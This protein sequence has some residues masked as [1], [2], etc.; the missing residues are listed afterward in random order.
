MHN[1]GLSCKN[2]SAEK[3]NGETEGVTLATPGR[4]VGPLGGEIIW[5]RHPARNYLPRICIDKK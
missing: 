5:R 3:S 1:S 2:N 4:L